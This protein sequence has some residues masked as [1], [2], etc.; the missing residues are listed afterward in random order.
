MKWGVGEARGAP[1]GVDLVTDRALGQMQPL[2]A[3]RAG[4]AVVVQRGRH[5]RAAR[6]GE[7]GQIEA[8][9]EQAVDV[10]HVGLRRAQHGIE[11][12]RQS[13]RPPGI[14]ERPFPVVDEFDDGQPLVHAPGERAVRSARVVLGRQHVH[15]VAR[16]QLPAQVERVD[17]GAGRVPGQEVVDRVQDAHRRGYRSW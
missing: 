13:G 9:V 7:A 8:Q 10:H 6:P 5:R 15:V 3:G 11:L 16:R 1:G 14:R 12:R 17:L 2:A 4:E